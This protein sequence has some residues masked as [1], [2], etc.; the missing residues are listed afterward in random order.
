MWDEFKDHPMRRDYREP[1]DFE[2][3]PTAHDEVLKRM[4]EHEDREQGTGIREQEDGAKA[5]L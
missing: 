3:E 2:Y 1:D 5:G 4:Q